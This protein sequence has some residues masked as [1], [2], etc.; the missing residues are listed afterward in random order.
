MPWKTFLLPPGCAVRNTQPPSRLCCWGHCCSQSKPRALRTWLCVIYS[1]QSRTSA[2]W[3]RTTGVPSPHFLE[4]CLTHY[5]GP[6]GGG[7]GPF[8]NPLPLTTLGNWQLRKWEGGWGFPWKKDA[9][10]LVP[11]CF[12]SILL[13]H[14]LSNIDESIYIK[15]KNQ[16]TKKD[17]WGKW[18]KIKLR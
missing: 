11:T 12:L 10:L 16:S 3:L 15:G 5:S 4:R 14:P 9:G 6:R 1:Q 13:A 2:F 18:T 17:T 8:C 7:Q